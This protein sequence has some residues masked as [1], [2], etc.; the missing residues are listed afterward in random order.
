MNPDKTLILTDK[1]KNELSRKSLTEIVYF[2]TA[3]CCTHVF[4]CKGNKYMLEKR[5]SQVEE[6]LPGED[7]FRIHNSWIINVAYVK[8]VNISK[9]KVILSTDYNQITLY[10]AH[11]RL[12]SFLDFMHR[13]FNI[14]E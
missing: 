8:R 14:L 3:G 5:I 10:I 12:K 11:R 4:C 6:K 13:R 7:F 9:R 2:E 1:K